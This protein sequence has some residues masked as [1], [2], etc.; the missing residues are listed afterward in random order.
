VLGISA[1][2][3]SVLGPTV[4]QATISQIPEYP[5]AG[6]TA[7]GTNG[8]VWAIARIGNTV[9]IGG[10]FTQ[11]LRSD[12]RSALRNDLMAVDA[13][14][15]ALLPWAPSVN[16][17]VFDIAVD[18]TTLLVGGDFTTV[19]GTARSN[20]AAINS[21]GAVE[22]WHLNTTNQV[23]AVTFSNGTLYL[24]GQFNFVEGETRIRLAAADLSTLPSA[25][26]TPPLLNWTPSV[27]HSVRSILVMPNG[28][29]LVAGVFDEITEQ[30]STTPDT[31][32][33]YI[34]ALTPPGP[35]GGKFA[36][37]DEHTT[38]F[39]WELAMMPD[40]RVIVGRG[41]RKGGTIGA[42]TEIGD[43]TWHLFANGDVQAVAYAD[44]RVIAGGHWAY[45]NGGPDGRT[46]LPRLA[47]IN[48]TTGK[49]DMSW[50]PWPDSTKGVWSVLGSSDRLF[51]G[52]DFTT[53]DHGAD[54]A[55][56]FAEFTITP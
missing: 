25:G 49:L 18:G 53:M 12:G 47:A 5:V 6:G 21:A 3:A 1:L 10:N 34:Q 13:V 15:G 36:Q 16:G 54:I 51:V 37:W 28:H 23:R 11:A 8:R 52:G 7:W 4:A 24:G 41:G 39:V 26:G 43:V 35:N 46:H 48:P 32:K 42:Y 40:G 33:P 56:H 31:T 17:I 55:N 44:G 29:V 27:N 14:T 50:Q 2:L 45:I 9:Y 22:N 38:D 20:F 30:G 19:N